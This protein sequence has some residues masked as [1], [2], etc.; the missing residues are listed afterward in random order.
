MISNKEQIKTLVLNGK[1]MKTLISNEKHEQCFSLEDNK[2]AN[3]QINKQTNK[4]RFIE[5]RMTTNE[6]QRTTEKTTTTCNE[7][8]IKDNGFQ[9]KTK[10]LQ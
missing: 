4:L 7:Q 10:D 1:H 3:K 2:Q 8:P 6:F 5:H 9:C